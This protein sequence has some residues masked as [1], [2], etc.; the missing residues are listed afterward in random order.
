MASERTIDEVRDALYA[1]AQS[2]NDEEIASGVVICVEYPGDEW[3]GLRTLWGCSVNDVISA[4]EAGTLETLAEMD[5]PTTN[6]ART[7]IVTWPM[8]QV[9]PSAPRP[10]ISDFK[11]LHELSEAVRAGRVRE[12]VKGEE[13]YDAVYISFCSLPT[14]GASF[15]KAPEDT[16]G[17]ASWDCSHVMLM[18]GTLK[19]RES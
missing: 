12:S 19:E 9:S 15:V 1:D 5:V 17:I 16:T 13:V 14:Y 6:E 2:F 8:T 4:I 7:M 18:D 10:R 11:D 3:Y